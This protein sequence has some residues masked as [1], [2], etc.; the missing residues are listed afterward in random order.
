M[1][2]NFIPGLRSPY[3]TVGGLFVF[4][5]MLDKIRLNQAGKLPPAWVEAMNAPTGLDAWCCRFLKIDYEALADETKSGGG[6]EELFEWACDHGRRPDAEEIEVWNGFMSKRGWRDE[7]A[8]RVAFR[9]E[10]AGYPPGSVETMF[11][12]LDLDEGR[13]PRWS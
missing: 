1:N 3:E 10:E 6:D 11:D 4:G 5:R 13:E 12:F 7:N 8:A 9:L 2:P